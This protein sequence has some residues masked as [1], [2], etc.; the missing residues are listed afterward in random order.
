[1]TLT[2]RTPASLGN[3]RGGGRVNRHRHHQTLMLERSTAEQERGLPDVQSGQGERRVGGRDAVVPSAARHAPREQRDEEDD[4]QE[5]G[6]HTPSLHAP[7]PAGKTLTGACG[8]PARVG[9]PRSWR[10]LGAA[11]AGRPATE[12]R[13]TPWTPPADRACSPSLEVAPVGDPT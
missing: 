11:L 9:P 6:G 8:E 12:D 10:P 13:M 5:E 7:V 3:G 4:E 2:E 1:M